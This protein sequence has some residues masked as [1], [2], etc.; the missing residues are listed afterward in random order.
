M[1]LK[2]FSKKIGINASTISRALNNYP[3]I[4]QK[5]LTKLV[6]IILT[7]Q[8]DEYAWIEEYPI[9]YLNEIKSIFE[10]S[11]KFTINDDLLDELSESIG[12][13]NI[14]ID[15]NIRRI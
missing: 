15:Y 6:D 5:L 10:N 2:D 13:E 3:D 9:R 8:L 14:K 1:N 11:F 7:E 12:K 4:S